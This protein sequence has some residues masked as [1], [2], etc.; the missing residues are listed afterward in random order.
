MK[1]IPSQTLLVIKSLLNFLKLF[2]GQI[3]NGS[4]DMYFYFTVT[5]LKGVEISVCCTEQVAWLLE[6]EGHL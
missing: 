2:E 5:P 6:Q 1:F 4:C 3:K